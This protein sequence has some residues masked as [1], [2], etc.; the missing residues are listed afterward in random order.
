[1]STPPLTQ[2]DLL[3]LTKAKI[4]YPQHAIKEVVNTYLSVVAE[5]VAAGQTVRLPAVGTLSA[6]LRPGHTRAYPRL[7][8]KQGHY[9]APSRMLVRFRVNNA[10]KQSVL[11]LPVPEQVAK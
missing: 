1:M 8:G 11:A 5:Q 6:T 9:T 3:R 2:R 10:L 7:S 4:G